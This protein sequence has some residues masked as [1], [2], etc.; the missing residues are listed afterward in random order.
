MIVYF[1]IKLHEMFNVIEQSYKCHKSHAHSAKKHTLTQEIISQ[2]FD[3]MIM[4][5]T[6]S[7]VNS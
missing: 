2:I 7:K 1:F 6:K 5:N 3:V 4:Q